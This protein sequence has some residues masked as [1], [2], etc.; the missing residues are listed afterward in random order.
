MIETFDVIVVGAGPGGYAA[1]IKAAKEGFRTAIIE[2]RTIGGTCLNSGCIPAKAMLH[3]AT[4]YREMKEGEKFGLVLSGITFNYRKILEY[5]KETI[6]KL[7]HGAEQ[8]LKT[9][10]VV[11]LKGKGVLEKNRRVRIISQ[12]GEKCYE[13]KYIILSTG[14]KPY[15]PLISGCHLK[16]FLTSD[17]L[18]QLE[19]RPESLLIIGG[20]ILGVEFAC[21]FADLGSKVTIVEILPKL[22]PNMDKEISHNIKMLLEK[23]GID[24]HTSAAI[25]SIEQDG[26]LCTCIFNENGTLMESSAR[27]V[28]C[29]AGRHP[30]MDNLFAEGAEPLIAQGHILVDKEFCTSMEGVYAIGDLIKGKQLAHLASAQGNYVI[31]KIAGKETSVDL[32][33]IP[34]CVYTSPEIASVGLTEDEAK[35]QGMEIQIGRFNIGANG[36]SVITKEERG[37]IKIIVEEKTNVIV[38]AQMMCARATDMIGEFVTAI[39]NKMTTKQFIKGIR[40]HP[41]YNEGVVEALRNVLLYK[42]DKT[43]SN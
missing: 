10:G 27:Y 15:I 37:F 33:V 12:A 20:G 4:L 25:Q 28:L 19:E 6:S 23:R 36:K 1:A 34:E 21:M 30:N 17:E 24:I 43:D 14:S 3:A 2:E 41:T 22:I 9:N 5:K 29:A 35:E 7:R 18:F 38:G 8:I 39:V 32:Q 13:G 31:E 40:A 26:E 11:I 16:N 42:Y